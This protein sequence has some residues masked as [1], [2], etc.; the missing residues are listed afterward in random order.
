IAKVPEHTNH[1]LTSVLVN[2]YNNYR[3]PPRPRR[4]HDRTSRTR[5]P[6]P[7]RSLRFAHDAA[8]AR[9]H[10][11]RVTLARARNRRQYRHFSL[12]HTVMLRLLP[13]RDPQ[14]LVE[15]LNKYLGQPHVNGF[16][17]RSY[18]HF[19]DHNHVLTALIGSSPAHL[20]VRAA[21]LD[22]EIV[23]GE[24]VVSNFFPVL[25]GRVPPFQAYHTSQAVGR[26]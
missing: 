9:I 8:R 19:R 11:H 15:L 6:H 22:P 5:H 16:S 26:S 18:L 4:A 2:Q 13:V 3:W 1:H 7:G 20:T 10:R 21:G 24:Y 14:Q 25:D 23:D 12:I 17:W